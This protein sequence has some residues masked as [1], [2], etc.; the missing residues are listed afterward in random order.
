MRK[1]NHPNFFSIIIFFKK[2]SVSCLDLALRNRLS[3]E[4]DSKLV[5]I[6]HN[7]HVQ[8]KSKKKSSNDLCSTDDLSS[9]DSKYTLQEFQEVE[10]FVIPEK[11]SSISDLD[12]S[13]T[14]LEGIPDNLGK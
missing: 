3:N 2:Y 5:Y 14:E 12:S 1:K 9:Q 11:I 6:A 13:L 4:N 8:G 10:E 7:R